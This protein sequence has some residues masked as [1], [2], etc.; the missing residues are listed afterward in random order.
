MHKGK[1][2]GEINKFNITGYKHINNGIDLWDK[3]KSFTREMD[4][5]LKV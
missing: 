4:L 1:V 2:K 3:V 5:N